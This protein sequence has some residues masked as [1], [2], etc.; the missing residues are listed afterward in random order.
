ML[1]TI[2]PNVTINGC[3]IISIT[4]SSD[5]DEGIKVTMSDGSVYLVKGEPK[6]VTEK[7]SNYIIEGE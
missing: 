5:E 6:K 1:L 2:K 7:I 4:Y 3:R